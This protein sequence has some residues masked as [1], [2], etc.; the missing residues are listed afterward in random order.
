[1]KL[2]WLLFWIIPLLLSCTV[3][4]GIRRGTSRIR[5]NFLASTTTLLGTLPSIWGCYGFAHMEVLLARDPDDL[6]FEGRGFIL[7]AVAVSTWLAWSLAER[8][9]RNW[10]IWVAATVALWNLA[11]W[12]AIIAAV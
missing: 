7:A 3:F 2:S 12:T 11:V 1:M 8:Q 10:T 6:A 4:N 9:W 5:H